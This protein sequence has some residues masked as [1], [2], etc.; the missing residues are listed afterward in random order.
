MNI[1]TGWADVD[2]S[3]VGVKEAIDG[4]KMLKAEGLQFDKCY[5]SYVQSRT[6]F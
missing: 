5:T 1:F 4:G 2:L 6:L 3:E